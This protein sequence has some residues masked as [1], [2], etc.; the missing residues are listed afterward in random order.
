MKHR[1]VVITPCRDESAYLPAIL[2]S[3]TFQTSPPHRWIIVD[4]GSKDGSAEI[5]SRWMQ[6]YPWIELLN[7][8]NRGPRQLG[9]GVV[10]AFR[11]GLR[12]LGKDPFDIVAKVDADLEFAP[13]TFSRILAHFQNPTVGMASGTTYLKT[14]GGLVSE[15]HAPYFVPG[16]AKFYRR[17]CFEQI[18]GLR[19]VYGWDIIDQID[20]R[21]HGWVT[22]RDPDI[23]IIHHRLQG[24]TFGPVKGRV[25]WGWGASAIGSHPLFAVC[26]GLYRMVERPWFIGGL[27][28]LWGYFSGCLDR[29]LERVRDPELIRYV[30]RE[31]V[32][33]LLHG[34]RLPD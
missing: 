31:Q 30:R 22:L 1:L 16:Q 11:D 33:R 19:S 25:I 13:D 32:H 20:A 12:H 7:R 29:K 10:A 8:D 24:S 27:A 23:P 9:P 5:I 21:R 2:R 15:R 4:D 18:G 28:F 6:E 34:N 14:K 3:I 17:A 26:R